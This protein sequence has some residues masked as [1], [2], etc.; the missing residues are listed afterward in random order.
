MS[1]EVVSLHDSQR[2]TVSERFRGLVR[3]TRNLTRRRNVRLILRGVAATIVLGVIV[4]GYFLYSS[5]QFYG[6]MID[7][8][9]ARGY[10]TSRAGIY[11]APR[12]LRP[13]QALT[14]ES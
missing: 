6:Q 5:Y 7:A 14:G 8:R 4:A 10:L 9:L 3:Q 12:T 13:G 11:A 1:I 2:Q